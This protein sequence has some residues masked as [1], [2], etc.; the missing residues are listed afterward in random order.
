MH[1]ITVFKQHMTSWLIVSDYHLINLLSGANQELNLTICQGFLKPPSETLG[2]YQKGGFW[3]VFPHGFW[4]LF[5]FA[6]VSVDHWWTVV[7]THSIGQCVQAVFTV[8]KAL[9]STH[10]PGWCGSCYSSGCIPFPSHLAPF[11]CLLRVG[12]HEGERVAHL[13]S[14]HLGPNCWMWGGAREWS[15]MVGVMRKGGMCDAH[16]NSVRVVCGVS[17]IIVT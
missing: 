10:W 17:H 6:F 11:S 3:I 16:C 1:P 13:V 15:M 2:F 14:Q 8:F 4:C 7:G 5:V 12:L 9:G